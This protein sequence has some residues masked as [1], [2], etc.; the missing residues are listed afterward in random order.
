MFT[1]KILNSQIGIKIYQYLGSA[2]MLSGQIN[3]RPIQFYF[4]ALWAR[5]CYFCVSIL[6]SFSGYCLVSHVG[7]SVMTDQQHTFKQDFNY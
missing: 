4:C 1:H 3:I 6:F 7:A 5:R 2:F